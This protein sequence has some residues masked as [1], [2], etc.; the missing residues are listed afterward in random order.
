M[1]QQSRIFGP[2]ARRSSVGGGASDQK[3][4]PATLS[5]RSN[6][7]K[8]HPFIASD[9]VQGSPGVSMGKARLKRNGGYD[10][11]WRSWGEI[12]GF[13]DPCT[14]NREL[15]PDVSLLFGAHL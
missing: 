11:G 1:P 7:R 10:S 9:I 14:P 4:W 15:D 13:G 8:V 3:C 6:T 2:Q 5:S 12:K